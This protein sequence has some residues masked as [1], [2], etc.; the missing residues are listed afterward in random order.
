MAPAI[1][2][3][4]KQIDMERKVRRDLPEDHPAHAVKVGDLAGVR[5][6][7]IRHDQKQEARRMQEVA[8]INTAEREA[9]K[10]EERRAKL[11]S[12]KVEGAIKAESVVRRIMNWPN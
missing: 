1:R 7:I 9:F 6:A 5:A 3:L 8:D 10:A 4:I 11:Q 12:R 2:M